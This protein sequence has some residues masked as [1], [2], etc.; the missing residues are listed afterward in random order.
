[1][2]K[3][4]KLIAD[5]SARGEN[6]PF[7]ISRFGQVKYSCQQI[8]DGWFHTIKADNWSAYFSEYED[9]TIGSVFIDSQ[10]SNPQIEEKS[11]VDAINTV[12]VI[13]KNGL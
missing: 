5:S 4:K 2:S 10:L 6:K 7:V 8:E 3:D 1:M 13:I 12:E 9:E 11:F